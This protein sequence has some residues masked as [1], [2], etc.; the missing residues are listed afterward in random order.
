MFWDSETFSLTLFLVS[1][2]FKLQR[3]LVSQ[4]YSGM[5]IDV[6]LPESNSNLVEAAFIKAIETWKHLWADIMKNERWAIGKM[7][8]QTGPNG[9]KFLAQFRKSGRRIWEQVIINP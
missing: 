9:R 5:G 2:L 3:L 6:R 1:L 8:P 4:P 7:K